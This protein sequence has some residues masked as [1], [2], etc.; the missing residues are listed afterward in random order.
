MQQQ[1]EKVEDLIKAEV[2]VKQINYL[3]G[4]EGFIKK[5]I[6]P[7]FVALGKRLGARM[8][9]VSNSLKQFFAGRH[10]EIGKRWPYYFIY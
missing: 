9:A 10:R 8:K 7:N 4:N 5:K 6:K 1:L 3:S 2:N